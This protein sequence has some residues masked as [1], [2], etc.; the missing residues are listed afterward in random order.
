MATISQQ[1]QQPICYTAAPSAQPT[2]RPV[3]PMAHILQRLAERNKRARTDNSTVRTQKFGGV[4][5]ILL[6]FTMHAGQQQRYREQ[7]NQFPQGIAT[8][9]ATR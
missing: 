2:Q 9:L 3:A 5:I 4:A 7:C 1:R 6:P 8:V